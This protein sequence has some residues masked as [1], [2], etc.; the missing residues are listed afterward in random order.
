MRV[1]AV[2]ESVPNLDPPLDPVPPREGPDPDLPD[3]VPDPEVPRP[4]LHPRPR[5]R[6]A[7]ARDLAP[8]GSRP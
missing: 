1:I 7:A 4:N 8:R 6:A 5:S 3:L 2:L